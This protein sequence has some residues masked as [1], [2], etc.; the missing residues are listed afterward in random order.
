MGL[1]YDHLSSVSDP[2]YF[3]SIS[4]YTSQ[5]FSDPDPF[6]DPGQNQTVYRTRKQFFLQIVKKFLALNCRTV[7][8][9]FLGDKMYTTWQIVPVP[10]L[11]TVHT[12]CY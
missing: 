6:P 5:V 2:K 1:I 12:H 9:N 7:F 3:L 10:F 8:T 4:G 11:H